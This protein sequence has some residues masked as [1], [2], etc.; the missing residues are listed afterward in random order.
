MITHHPQLQFDDILFTWL[1]SIRSAQITSLMTAITFLGSRYF[2]FPCYAVL[3]IYYL[4]SRKKLWFAVAIALT[5]FLGNQLLFFMQDVFHR[6]RPL[7]PLIDY[8][9]GY[10]YPSGHSFASFVFA[11]LLSFLVCQ[12]SVKTK[13]KVIFVV[14]CFAMATIIAISRIYLHVHYPTD[15]LG[16][17]Y[18]SMVWLIPCLWILYFVD[19]MYN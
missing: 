7:N 16:G 1:Q 17:F 4:F 9:N 8:V 5:G 3:T 19:K 18:L 14:T 11:G 12:K 13:W 6:Q 2:L 15:V 10:G